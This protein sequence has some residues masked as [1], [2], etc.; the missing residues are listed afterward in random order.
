MRRLASNQGWLKKDLYIYQ[1]GS[2]RKITEG[3]TNT[4]GLD[5]IKIFYFGHL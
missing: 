5:K 4:L 2:K 3:L 1:Y